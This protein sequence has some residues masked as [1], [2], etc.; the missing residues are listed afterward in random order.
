MRTAAIT[1][2]ADGRGRTQQRSSTYTQHRDDPAS[3]LESTAHD[4]ELKN[5]SAGAGSRA[6]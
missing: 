5:D 4:D 3:A 6:R 1:D 2:V